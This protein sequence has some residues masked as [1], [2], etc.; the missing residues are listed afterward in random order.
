MQHAC[1]VIRQSYADHQ[2]SAL[3]LKRLIKSSMPVLGSFSSGARPHWP[4]S[5]LQ[6]L[7]HKHT[8]TRDAHCTAHSSSA[9]KFW[10]R[11]LL[12]C[13]C[14]AFSLF[15]TDLC[16][17]YVRVQTISY[18]QANLSKRQHMLHTRSCFC[19]SSCFDP[20]SGTSSALTHAKAASSTS[21]SF[22]LCAAQLSCS[23]M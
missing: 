2:S 19:L 6:R 11:T 9:G 20:K 21:A 8:C 10:K 22:I 12:C 13:W 3:T 18:C 4:A 23:L 16:N 17:G 7:L 14:A 5:R 1:A 15:P